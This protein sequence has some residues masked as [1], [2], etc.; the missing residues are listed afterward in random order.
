MSVRK[1]PRERPANPPGNLPALTARLEGQPKKRAGARGRR[2]SFATK[3]REYRAFLKDDHDWDWLYILR[4]LQY[5]LRRTREGIVYNRIVADRQRIAQQIRQVERLFERVRE[6]RYFDEIS[7]GFKKKYG[8]LKMVF[9]K[10][11][12]GRA[13]SSLTFTFTKVKAADL[14]AANREWHWLRLRA[15][16]LQRAELRQAFSLMEK[17]LF[18]WWD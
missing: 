5:K 11:E 15:E 7:T 6:D 8:Q 17:H 4:L 3:L 2:Q 9:G 1:K 14:P 16:K 10:K 12:P 18:G 13:G